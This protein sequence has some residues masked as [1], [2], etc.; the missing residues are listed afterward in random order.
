MS[1]RKFRVRS[2]VG[3]V[4]LPNFGKVESN[5]ILVGDRFGI[6][7]PTWLVDI[8]GA[9]PASTITEQLPV[10]EAAPVAPPQVRQVLTEKLPV[11]EEKPMP[12]SKTEALML[13]EQLPTPEESS[14]GSEKLVKSHYKKS[15]KTQD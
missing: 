14:E 9:P 13:T 5:Q 8:S 11:P 6:Y 3:V 15:K 2:D 4:V 7:C 12:P 10:P 1:Q